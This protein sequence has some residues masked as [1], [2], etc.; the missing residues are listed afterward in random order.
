MKHLFWVTAENYQF[1]KQDEIQS[2]HLSETCCTLQPVVIYL[3]GCAG[4]L[5]HDSLCFISDDN[6]HDTNFVYEVQMLLAEP[7]QTNYLHIKKFHYFPDGCAGQYKNYKDFINLCH[8]R[9]DFGLDAEW[10]FLPL[11]MG[12]LPVYRQVCEEV[13]CKETFEHSNLRLQSIH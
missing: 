12:S 10:T 13:C 7:V 2:Y 5:K 3:L 1:T 9:Q 4:E 8:H 11:V 6:T